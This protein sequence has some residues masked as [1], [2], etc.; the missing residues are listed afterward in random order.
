[1]QTITN[2]E[3]K[4]F[5]NTCKAVYD[6]YDSYNNKAVLLYEGN[7]IACIDFDTNQYTI[8]N[9]IYINDVTFFIPTSNQ[10]EIIFNH[11]SEL[12]ADEVSERSEMLKDDYD[13]REHGV[14]GFGY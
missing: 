9:H 8:D 11:L 7:D 5:L 6:K 3:L 14:Y 1:M 13:V 2:N 10:K 4:N 12:V